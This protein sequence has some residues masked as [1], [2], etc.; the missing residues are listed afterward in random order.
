MIFQYFQVNSQPFFSKILAGTALKRDLLPVVGY[1]RLT[2]D[3]YLCTELDKLYGF[4]NKIEILAACI[5]STFYL[6][7]SYENEQGCTILER[8]SNI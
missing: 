4:K 5:V 2:R 7:Y 6:F 1:E 8:I 3:I